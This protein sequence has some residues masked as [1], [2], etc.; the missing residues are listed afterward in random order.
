APAQMQPGRAFR[1]KSA[2]VVPPRLRAFRFNRSREARTGP[3]CLPQS[4]PN[5]GFGGPSLSNKPARPCQAPGD[6]LKVRKTTAHV[7]RLKQMNKQLNA[8]PDLPHRAV[9]LS[10]AMSTGNEFRRKQRSK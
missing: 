3:A 7:F 6:G 1:F 2:L 5:F 8:C 9:G 10:R 4:Q